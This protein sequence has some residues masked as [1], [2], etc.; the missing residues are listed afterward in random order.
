MEFH[1]NNPKLSFRRRELRN[2]STKQERLL[3]G[4]LKNSQLGVKF[5]RQYGVGYYIVDFICTEKRL[6]IEIDGD[7]H[8][9]DDGLK[10]DQERT[11]FLKAFDYTVLRFT[12]PEVMKSLDGVVMKIKEFL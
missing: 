9:R 1:Y 7:Q 3:W 4:C 2:K 5:R 8:Y 12:N 6:I 10:Y 11:G